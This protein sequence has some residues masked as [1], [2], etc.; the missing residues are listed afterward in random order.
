M[1]AS[2]DELRVEVAEAN[3][4]IDRAGLVTLSF[5]NVSGVDRDAGVL[6][7]KPS[8]APYAAAPSSS[9]RKST[10]SRERSR[11]SCPSAAASCWR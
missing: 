1:T 4:A 9:T 3:A 7:I 5:G 11:E 10:P 2:L 8:G 6:V